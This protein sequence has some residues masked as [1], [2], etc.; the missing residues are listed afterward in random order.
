[1]RLIR[2]VAFT[3]ILI[4]SASCVAQGI[5]QGSGSPV[6][7]QP[8]R[9]KPV[10]QG[11]ILGH[12]TCTD[13]HRPA[14]GAKIMLYPMAELGPAGELENGLGQPPMAISGLDGSFLVPHVP[15]GEYAV[16]T[17]A[18][19]YLTP[20]DGIDYPASTDANHPTDGIAERKKMDATLRK[21]APVVRLNGAE[22]ERID[23]ELQRG[24][25]LSGKVVF[26][27]G[28]PASQ[29]RVILQ[30]NEPAKAA[31]NKSQAMDISMLARAYMLQQPLATDDQGHFRIAG[32]APGTYRLAVTQPFDMSAAD[33]G[34]E[35]FGAF[36]PAAQQ[37][38]KLTIYSGST[39]HRKDAKLYDLRAGDTVDGIEIVLPL[40]GL[41]SIRGTATA[42]DGTLLN[43]GMIT[44]VDTADAAISFHS[45]VYASGDFRFNGIPEGTYELKVIGGRI[46]E[47]FA[48]LSFPLN[49]GGTTDPSEY[50]QQ[51]ENFDRQLKPSRAFADTTVPVLVQT[52][53][54]DNLTVT[55]PETKLPDPPSPSNLPVPP[56]PPAT[57]PDQP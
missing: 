11:S 56:D 19:G 26:A 50:Q 18:A 9:K 30:K 5:V 43:S 24:A 17:F 49:F 16:L 13:T 32:I 41:H 53:D 40:D 39:L 33:L 20:L 2:T 10:P 14:R 52:S 51:L 8:P 45:T 25:I 1:M 57:P 15:P 4:A 3:L 31:S 42:K 6:S 38:G 34:I 36:D 21:S 35:I 48:D 29:L 47:N 12:V 55:L 54:I 23:I 28:S 22:T 7:N 27:D 44:L 46:Y 37:S